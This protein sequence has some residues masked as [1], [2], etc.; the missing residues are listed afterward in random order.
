MNMNFVYHE[1]ATDLVTCNIIVPKALFTILISMKKVERYLPATV[2]R[3]FVP[4]EPGVVQTEDGE[5]REL[6]AEDT[7]E[8]SEC[9]LEALDASISGV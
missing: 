3:S 2:K 7:K 5:I 9:N 6:T 4:G 8:C 1:Y